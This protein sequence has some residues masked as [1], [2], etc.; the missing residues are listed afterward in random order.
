MYLRGAKVFALQLG[1]ALRLGS[2]LL[3]SVELLDL[4]ARLPRQVSCQ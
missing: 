2:P 4:F 3:T 1:S